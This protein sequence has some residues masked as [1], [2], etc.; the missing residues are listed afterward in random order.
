METWD[1]I[2]PYSIYTP[3]NLKNVQKVLE[4]TMAVIPFYIPIEQVYKKTLVE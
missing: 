2:F 3:S 4:I 1:Y